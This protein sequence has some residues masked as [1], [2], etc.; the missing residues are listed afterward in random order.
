MMRHLC[1]K[2]KIF[3]IFYAFLGASKL[4]IHSSV[5]PSPS[6]TFPLCMMMPPADAGW[7]PSEELDALAMKWPLCC[8]CCLVSRPELDA[9]FCCLRPPTDAPAG[10][11]MRSGGGIESFSSSRDVTENFWKEGGGGGQDDVR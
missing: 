5:L 8:G 6:V 11:G 2:I 10:T 7:W 4:C 9:D 1:V 3:T